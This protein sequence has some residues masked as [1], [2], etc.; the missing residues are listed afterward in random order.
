[1]ID[2]SRDTFPLELLEIVQRH[3]DVH[4]PDY[5]DQLDFE[6]AH[7]RLQCERELKV[8]EIQLQRGLLMAAGDERSLGRLGGHL[9]QT[10]L[11][12]LRGLAWLAG[13]RQPRTLYGLVEAAEHSIARELGGIRRVLDDS[14]PA[15]WS[16]F[17][18]ACMPTCAGLREVVDRL[19]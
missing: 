7:V 4:G 1:M 14:D 17:S 18:A 15:D 16:K 5:F 6:P 3:V 9:G 12:I 11:R 10:L 13:D 2:D 19:P 8:I